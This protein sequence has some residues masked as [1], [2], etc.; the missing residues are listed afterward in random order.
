MFFCDIMCNMEP[1]YYQ[2]FLDTIKSIDKQHKPK[3]LMHVCCAPCSSRCLEVLEDYFDVTVLYY[4]PNISPYEEYKK[5]LLEEINF[6][7]VAHPN[8]KV[9]E[10]VYDNENFENMVK[11]LEDLPEGGS[12]CKLCYNMRIKKTGEYAKEH[13]FDYFTTSLTVSRYKNSKVLNEIGENVAKQIG[14]KYLFSDFKKENGY[15]RSIELS[16]KYNLYR[17][18]YCGCKYSKIAREKYEQL[19]KSKIDNSNGDYEG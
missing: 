1:N 7:K 8:V 16:K 11:G 15:Q 10:E 18:N 5:R 6:V 17:Q 12:R 4:N 2:I 14:V 13:N 19:L 3:L 9:I